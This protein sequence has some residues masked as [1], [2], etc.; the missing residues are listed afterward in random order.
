MV[1]VPFFSRLLRLTVKQ[2]HPPSSSYEQRTKHQAPSTTNALS[3]KCK[4]F[5]AKSLPISGSGS[6]PRCR[7]DA[8]TLTCQATSSLVVWQWYI[9]YDRKP[10]LKRRGAN[11]SGTITLNLPDS[12]LQRAQ[13][14]AAHSEQ[15]VSDFLSETIE[16]SLGPLGQAPPPASQWP[17]A[18]VLKAVELRL[19]HE[20][21]RRLSELLGR[22]REGCLP[23]LEAV[24]L[25]RL[26]LVYQEGLLRKAIA[27]REAVRRG[28]R[29]PP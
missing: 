9:G 29:S 20:D 23:E 15:P 7:S 12:V 16:L 3:A 17:D 4:V 13:L 18:E 22:Q 11:M 10:S 2:S 1:P 19:S 27:L 25:R 28:L 14:W 24:E 26:M 21:D 8:P 6:L 5:S